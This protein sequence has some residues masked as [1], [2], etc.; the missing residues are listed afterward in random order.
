MHTQAHT[1][2][3]RERD[4]RMMK[5]MMGVFLCIAKGVGGVANDVL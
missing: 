1:H 3:E 4:V 2:R 5:H